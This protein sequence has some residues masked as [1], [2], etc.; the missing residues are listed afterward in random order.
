MDIIFFAALAFFIF[1]KLN[2]QLGKV[3]DE[4][5]KKIAE[6]LIQKRKEF[7][8]LYN[9]ATAMQKQAKTQQMKVVSGHNTKDEEDEENEETK[10]LVAK[11]AAEED[12]IGSLSDDNRKTFFE[13]MHSCKITTEFFINGAKSAFEMILK[14]F[15][16]EDLE[17][18]KF[19]LAEKIYQG[20]KAALDQ[21]RSQEKNL[22]TNLISIEKVQIIS[23]L[24]VGNIASIAVRLTSQQI[25]YLTNKNGQVVEGRKDEILQL[26]DVWTFKKDLT[27]QNPNWLVSATSS[28]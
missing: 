24:K 14:S 5:R 17:T 20:F 18:L 13:I 4:E 27:S 12:I 15:A 10:K 1:F 11:N 22:I 16:N 25:N 21:R 8:D 3:D 28:S 23:V 9:K 6:K 2:K 7:L 19:L 26:T